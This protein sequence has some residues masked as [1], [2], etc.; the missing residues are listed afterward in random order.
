M[1]QILVTGGA[2]FIDAHFCRELINREHSVTVLDDLSGGF[3]DNLPDELD[4]VQGSINDVDL[5]MTLF[6]Q[7]QF[8][9][10][11]H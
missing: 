9:Y 11:Y 6:E 7:K 4:F 3:A 1:S 10:V 2:G 8:T 5:V